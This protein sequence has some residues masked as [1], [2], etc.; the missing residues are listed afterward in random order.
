MASAIAAILLGA[1]GAG[2]CAY[3]LFRFG[4]AYAHH[5]ADVPRR[6]ASLEGLAMCCAVAWVL[7]MM[8]QVFAA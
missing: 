1:G 6:S 4:R 3:A 7:I 5:F 8:A 2:L